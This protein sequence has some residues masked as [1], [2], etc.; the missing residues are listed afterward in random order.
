[1]R[2]GIAGPI[3][4]APLAEYLTYDVDAAPTGLGG[5][6]I[7]RLVKALLR[8]GHQVSV[9]TLD[10][11]VRKP[12]ILRGASLSIYYGEYRQKHKMR[13]FM[14]VERGNIRDFILADKPDLVNAHWTYEFALG[15]LETSIPTVVTVNDRASRILR[16]N[17]NAYRFG[18]LLMN[19]ATIL[20]GS[21]FT[22]VSP[23]VQKHFQKYVRRLIAL[24]PNFLNDEEFT[25]K[26]RRLN[27]DQPLV[28]SINNGFTKLKNVQAVLHAFR[29]I[30]K[31][32]ASCRLALVGYDFEEGGSA[33]RW[34][35]DNHLQ[36][37]VEF[38]GYSDY[39]DVASIL[40]GADLLIH[41]SLEES[42]GLTL[43]E[44]MA[45]GIPVIAGSE[46]G[47]AP[48]VLAYG[49][50]GLLVDV[51]S[52]SE[53]ADVAISLLTNQER[54]RTFSVAGFQHASDSFRESKVIHV[55]LNKYQDLFYASASTR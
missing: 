12:L 18:R 11:V 16:F 26:E 24:T 37:G 35:I 55:Y 40:E 29:A 45:K 52:P 53:I 47:A 19:Y 34:A 15:A 38:V 2:I 22:A 50:A 13:D 17:F 20:R 25:W 7:V 3:L 9:Y 30:R 1:M 28:V 39:C 14:K 27:I 54:W 43:L 23:Y 4:T 46:S 32:V 48:W 31:Q 44:A 6:N 33:Q 36:R 49:K 41:P 8:K 42:F 51:R 21:E 5:I 10:Q